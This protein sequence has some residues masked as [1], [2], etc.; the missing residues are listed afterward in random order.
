MWSELRDLASQLI[1]RTLPWPRSGP[2][3][4]VNAVTVLGDQVKV[5]MSLVT[6]GTRCPCCHGP[7]AGHFQ[8][9]RRVHSRYIRRPTDMTWGGLTTQLELHVRRFHCDTPDC[10]QQIF[11]EQLPQF[12]RRYGPAPKTGRAASKGHFGRRT[13]WPSPSNG[14]RGLAPRR[15]TFE[16]PLAL[17]G[18]LWLLA[19]VAGGEAGSSVAERFNIP[20][21][22]DTLLRLTRRRDDSVNLKTPRVLGVDEGG[23]SRGHWAFHKGHR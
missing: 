3:L 10:T 4:R 2:L 13:E 23:P 19:W 22:A 17:E 20:I 21:S 9:S 11:A 18:Q 16:G 1:V 8:V 12:L 5:T 6:T 14:P 7:A 15:A